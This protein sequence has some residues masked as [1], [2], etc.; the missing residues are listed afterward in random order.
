MQFRSV[1]LGDIGEGVQE[2]KMLKQQAEENSKVA[3]VSAYGCNLV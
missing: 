2:S 1:V 3:T